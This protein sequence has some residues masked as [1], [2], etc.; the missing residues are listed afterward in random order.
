VSD[1]ERRFERIAD[2]VVEVILAH[3]AG[4]GE[5]ERV[6]EDQH[7]QLLGAA[8]NGRRLLGME[9]GAV[10]VGAD[11]DPA[12]VELGH[13]AAHLL[14]GETRLLQWHRAHADQ[15][16]GDVWRRLRPCHR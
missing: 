2:Q 6:D 14:D 3:P 4:V 7:A 5:A 9:V 12:Q 8:Q 1:R 10:D 13:A 16:I 11:L 15:A